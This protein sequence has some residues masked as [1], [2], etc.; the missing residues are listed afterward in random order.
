MILDAHEDAYGKAM[1][2]Y[3]HHG[4]GWEIVERED[5]CAS[6]GAGPELYFA[7][8]RRWHRAERR[9]MRFVRGLVLDIG[10]GA[11]R[12]ML[13]LRERGLEVVGIDNSPGAIEV[14]RLRGLSGAQ[15]LS[16]EELDVSV[17]RFDTVLMLGGGLG[18]LGT[19]ARAQRTLD[20][21]AQMTTGRDPGGQPR[22]RRE[23]RS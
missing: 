16:L 18:L 15:A 12:A 13:H 19:P 10:C 6:I 4:E 14:C 17:G 2:D 23:W 20:Q 9:A 8:F 5:G 11:G 22:P 21:L 3:F 1:L 7:G